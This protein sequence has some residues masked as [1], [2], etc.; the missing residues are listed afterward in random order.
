MSFLAPLYLLAALAIGLPIAFH[1]I[2]RTPKGRH[3]FSSV[4]FLTPDPPRVTK[5]SRLEDL[6]LL[7]LRS[8][9][10]LLLAFAFARPFL[11]SH[12]TLASSEKSGRQVVLLIDRSASLQ[13][14]N[15]WADVQTEAQKVIRR[16]HHNDRFSLIAFDATSQVVIPFTEWDA[17]PLEARVDSA[18]AK[19]KTIQP[20]WS[21][22]DLGSALVSASQLLNEGSDQGNSNRELILISDMQTGGNWEA[23]NSYH[24]PANVTV[25]VVEIRPVDSTNVSMQFAAS[26]GTD[27]PEV[28]RVLLA[29]A[30]DSGGSTFHLSWRDSMIQQP[31]LN[32]EKSQNTTT[33]QS[34]K[35]EPSIAQT[36]SLP[37]GQSRVISLKK[38]QTDG[39]GPTL[40]LSG[41][42]AT[43]DNTL[44][45]S[46]SEK[47]HWR[48]GYLG[49]NRTASDAELRF[50]LEAAF[51]DDATRAIEFVD[52]KK[53]TSLLTKSDEPVT[54]L[55]V[56][57]S[58]EASQAESIRN[59]ITAGHAA[60]FVAREPAQASAVYSILGVPPAEITQVQP[61][62]YALLQNI[63]FEH[64]VFRPFDDPR[65]SDFSRLKIWKYQKFSDRSLPERQVLAT[66]DDGSPAFAEIPLSQGKLFLL[67]TGWNR[68][69]SDFAVSTKFVPLMNALLESVAPVESTRMQ[70]FVGE[71][72]V[73]KDLNISGATVYVKHGD[74][75]SVL[76]N[77]TNFTF[78]RPGYYLFAN[79]QANLNPQSATVVAVNIPS[80]ESR[81]TAVSFDSLKAS[82]INLLQPSRETVIE[83][84]PSPETQRQARNFELEQQQ[85][86]WRWAIVAVLAVLFVESLVAALRRHPAAPVAV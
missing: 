65:F 49:D 64:P 75:V 12:D 43:F 52:W 48:I 21:S 22:T 38:P 63:R 56:T 36:F 83:G 9:A 30:K 14:E 69:E 29:N 11:R 35:N 61:A 57:G 4:M 17:L 80:S 33:N 68:D 8:V 72:V 34:A 84:P 13:R 85:Q 44:Y 51:P 77:Q 67:T 19:L 53:D 5:R 54:F 45:L 18:L 1:L 70:K 58:V 74:E 10:I 3:V 24:W 50:Y 25:Q 59:W 6:F 47:K 32:Q 66:Y 39:I 86:W 23:L 28:V 42:A 15:C 2:S 26:T 46:G 73:L 20:G 79:S 62:T 55:I 71:S 41:D 81:T 76:E 27:D 7:L 82:G 16:L 78:D 60:L 40:V 37:A 31:V